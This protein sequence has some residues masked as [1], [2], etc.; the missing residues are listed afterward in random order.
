MD[1]RM[2]LYVCD[3]LRPGP[4]EHQPDER[5]EPVIVEWAEA[6]RMAYDGRIEDAKTLLA[7][8]LGDRWRMRR[9]R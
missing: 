3:D 6:L 9:G 1:E 7:I 8:L 2:Y 4:T 5:L